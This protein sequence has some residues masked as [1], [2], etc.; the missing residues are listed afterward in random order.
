MLNSAQLGQI[1]AGF[2]CN[3]YDNLLSLEVN[4]SS[5]ADFPDSALS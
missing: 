5:Q 4:F 2:R 3:V 1:I